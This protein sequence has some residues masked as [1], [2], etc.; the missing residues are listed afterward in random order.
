MSDANSVEP[1]KPAAF[2]LPDGAQSEDLAYPA[3]PLHVLLATTGSVASIKAPL[4][5]EGLLK[6]RPYAL[7]P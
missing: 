3:R 1:S 7:A 5:V 2:D 4:I 6:V